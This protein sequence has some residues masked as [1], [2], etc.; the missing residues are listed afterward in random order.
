M[1]LDKWRSLIV[2]ILSLW[3]VFTGIVLLAELA[4]FGKMPENQ[5]MSIIQESQLLLTYGLA[6]IVIGVGPAICYLRRMKRLDGEID[7]RAATVLAIFACNPI[8]FLL[9]V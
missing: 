4:T 2:V 5:Q 6:Y 7:Y 8:L 9:L 3:Q 1:L